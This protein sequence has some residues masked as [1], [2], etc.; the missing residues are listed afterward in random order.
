MSKKKKCLEADIFKSQSED[1]ILLRRILIIIQIEILCHH[2][3]NLGKVNYYRYRDRLPGDGGNCL[4][5]KSK[6]IANSCFFK[7]DS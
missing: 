1:I 6:L 3:L 7:Q 4:V 2:F 5:G